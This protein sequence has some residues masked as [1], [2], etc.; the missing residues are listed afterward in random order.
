MLLV[1]AFK[2]ILVYF[3]GCITFF[4][5]GQGRSE[6]VTK[7]PSKT[8][9][10]VITYLLHHKYIYIYKSMWNVCIDL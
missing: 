2:F 7:S 4:Q 8:K 6:K 10:V 3:K 5:D 9:K 1:L